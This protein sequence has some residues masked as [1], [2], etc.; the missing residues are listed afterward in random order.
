LTLT[1]RNE[2][3]AYDRDALIRAMADHDQV[4]HLALPLRG[5]RGFWTDEECAASVR[6]AKTV[7]EAGEA[8][9]V[10]RLLMP[11]SVRAT[12]DEQLFGHLPV[13]VADTRTPET[14]YGRT[15]LEIEALARG[16]SGKTV[17]V[18]CVRLGAIHH[19]DFPTPD[20]LARRVWLSH[21]DCAG[22]M[23]ACID[24]PVVPGRFSV[25]Y[26]ISDLPGRILDVSNPFGWRPMTTSVGLRRI[27]AWKVR[28]INTAIRG[29]LRLRSRLK[30]LGQRGTP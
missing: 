26:A 1:D 14:L 2:L 7:L 11:S 12:S 6:M 9:G 16:A 18:S 13:G 10:R 19:P 28:Q 25:W 24:A 8:A 30:A 3:D 21:E 27:L 20:T 23:R 5:R 17:E 4:I 29:R 15:R 22:L